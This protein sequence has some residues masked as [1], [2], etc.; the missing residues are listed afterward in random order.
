[1][2]TM[3]MLGL[4]A[5]L[6]AAAV[7]LGWWAL[8]QGPTAE[9]NP[10][11][12]IG[13]DTDVSG[14]D[15]PYANPSG[16]NDLDGDTVVE[17]VNACTQVPLGTQAFSLDVWVTDVTLLRGI[18][19]DVTYSSSLLQLTG[20]A[21]L[22]IGGVPL[23]LNQPGSSLA[24]LSDSLPD[25]DGSYT[26]W[27][28]DTGQR[29]SGSG[30]LVRLTFQAKT[31]SGTS[32]IKIA[33]TYLRSPYLSRNAGEPI[34][35]VDGDGTYDGTILNAAIAVGTA[36]CPTADGD[37]DGVL[38]ILDNCPSD[39]NPDQAD[40]DY[41]SRGDACDNCDYDTNEDQ[42]NTDGDSMGNV[43]DP[44][45]DNDGVPDL[46]DTCP[47]V[48]NPG[49]TNGDGDTVGDACDNCPTVTNQNQANGDADTLGDACDNCP[50]FANQNQLDT[51]G[52]GQGDACD[53]DDD[54]DGV[55]DFKDG[56][57]A[58]QVDVDCDNDGICDG[59]VDQS[60]SAPGAPPGGCV[61]GPDNCPID[62][63]P[64]EDCDG[65]PTTPDEQCDLDGDDIGD[66]CDLDTDGDG[67]PNAQEGE[68][69]ELDPDCDN[70]SLGLGNPLYFRDGVEAFM[71]TDPLDA[72]PDSPSHDAWP[73]DF[74]N[75]TR[76]NLGDIGPMRTAFNSM[77][78]QGN[79]TRRV[80]L[81][82]D[83]RVNLTDIG[84]LRLYFNTTCS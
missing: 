49:Q 15:P 12:A 61:A 56:A 10:G 53:G 20:R 59:P 40:G 43:C 82:A 35:D 48:S 45:D 72:C 42:L 77:E 47:L 41:D 58:C 23:F 8:G 84:I 3:C 9:A 32:L 71:G 37:S 13:I 74:N 24:D 22:S 68:G 76:V 33:H 29:E 7:F 5:G 27:V 83:G 64:P 46:S 63:N 52:D 38:N 44:D 14:N 18:E 31:T 11:L 70:D 34:G 19:M 25:T 28:N 16:G 51:D 62:P 54:N 78:G 73:P 1:M 66:V 80:D 81:S 36:T 65:N 26:I 21:V 17:T 75:D 79:Y 4:G 57:P 55:I 2:K 60:D 30:V 50:T 69:C 39:A 6:L 67:L